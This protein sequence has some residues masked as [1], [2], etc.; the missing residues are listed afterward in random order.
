MSTVPITL[1]TNRYWFESF[2]H[3]IKINHIHTLLFIVNRVLVPKVCFNMCSSSKYCQ[4]IFML[5]AHI[6]VRNYEP[7]ITLLLNVKNIY[8]HIN[9]KDKTL[10]FYLI[11][12]MWHLPLFL[13]AILVKTSCKL[14]IYR[15]IVG[16]LYANTTS[17]QHL[18]FV[19]WKIYCNILYTNT[20]RY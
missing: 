9:M 6:S 11:D 13:T 10:C 3:W 19:M 14:A 5:V 16:L 7:C 1:I 20:I 2:L 8:L 17:L 12:Y 15:A 4:E 18:R